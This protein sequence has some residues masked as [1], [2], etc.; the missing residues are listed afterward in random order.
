MLDQSKIKRIVAY[1]CSFTAATETAEAEMWGISEEELNSLKEKYPHAGEEYRKIEKE[2]SLKIEKD[3]LTWLDMKQTREYHN[4]YIKFL[5]DKIGVPW[6]NNARPGSSNKNSIFRLDLDLFEDNLEPGDLVIIGLTTPERL[7]WLQSF[8]KVED[9]HRVLNYSENVQ[10]DPAIED[11]LDKE[12]NQITCLYELYHT[13]NYLDSL[14]KQLEEKGITLIQIPVINNVVQLLNKCR[15]Y[16]DSQ[17]HVPYDKKGYDPDKVLAM[18]ASLTDLNSFY[19]VWSMFDVDKMI[20]K[21][22]PR[23][24]GFRHPKKIA[25]Q[26]YADYLYD[27][28]I[29]EKFEN[30]PSSTNQG[31]P[32]TAMTLKQKLDNLRLQDPFIYD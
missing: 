6:V 20:T 32:F 13:V 29:L 24:H 18:I 10:G 26:D 19:N 12:F 17:R 5:A 25:H 4:S 15:K 14:S 8:S 28:L 30:R 7:F 16:V 31:I 23:I 27:V 22:D 1:G 2:A 21:G 3:Y 9:R 11:R